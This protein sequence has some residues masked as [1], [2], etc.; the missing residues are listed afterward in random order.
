MLLILA[1]SIIDYFEGDTLELLIDISMAVVL[2]IS[3]V[4][5]FKFNVDRL[6]YCIGKLKKEN[7]RFVQP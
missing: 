5:I 3:T 6:I 7:A 2:I 4:A 1:F